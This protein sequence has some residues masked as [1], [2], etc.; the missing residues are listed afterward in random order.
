MAGLQCQANLSGTRVRLPTQPASNPLSAT[1]VPP[2][3]SRAQNKFLQP[4]PAVV[5]ALVGQ[6]AAKRVGV[7]AHFYMDPEVQGVL[8]S[9]GGL[10]WAPPRGEVRPSGWVGAATMAGWPGGEA[11]QRRQLF[12][13]G[14][15]GR[16]ATSLSSPWWA[17]SSPFR[18]VGGAGCSRWRGCPSRG[19]ASALLMASPLMVPAAERW[20]HINISDSLVMADG[21]VKMAEAGCK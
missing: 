13:R 17:Q 2:P 12:R 4:D 15:G 10:G 3:P 16:N 7:V 1:R 5:D 18:V 14:V 19:A 11:E 8:S 9:A 6:L 21:A 20:P